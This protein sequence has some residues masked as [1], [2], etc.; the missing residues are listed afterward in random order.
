MDQMTRGYFLQL[1]DH[2]HWANRRVLDLLREQG[3]KN[4]RARKLLAHVLASELVWMT[5]LQGQDSSALAIW[6]DLS[7]DECAALV[8]QNSAAYKRFLEDLADEDFDRTVAYKNS[9][10]EAFRTPIRDILSH[11]AMHGAYHR[12]QIAIVVRDAGGVPVNTDFITFVR[13]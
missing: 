5:R 7:F 11:V 6:P 13:V 1:Y 12:G 9:K 4:E 2:A 10:G 3:Q 8:E